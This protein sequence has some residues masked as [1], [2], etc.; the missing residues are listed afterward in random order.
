MAG[1]LDVSNYHTSDNS[2]TRLLLTTSFI[3]SIQLSL[4]GFH[5][6]LYGASVTN[7]SMTVFLPAG[8]VPHYQHAPRPCSYLLIRRLNHQHIP[9]FRSHWLLRDAMNFDWVVRWGMLTG[10]QLL[11]VC[12]S[13]HCFL[14]FADISLLHSIK[15]TTFNFQNAKRKVRV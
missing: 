3:N 7:S 9:C 8:T 13:R 10:N 12:I 4:P 15:A 1:L 6:C 14:M 2:R 11:L 5:A